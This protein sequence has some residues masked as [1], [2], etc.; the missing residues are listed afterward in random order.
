MPRAI[1][2]AADILEKRRRED[3]GADLLVQITLRNGDVGWLAVRQADATLTATHTVE[4]HDRRFM[5]VPARR[6]LKAGLADLLTEQSEILR[7]SKAVAIN[8]HWELYRDDFDRRERRS[9]LDREWRVH[10]LALV[11]AEDRSR[12]QTVRLVRLSC[13]RTSADRLDATQFVLD[14]G[15]GF[16]GWLRC[17]AFGSGQP[18]DVAVDVDRLRSALLRPGAGLSKLLVDLTTGFISEHD[19]KLAFAARRRFL[20]EHCI[21][22]RRTR[23]AVRSTG[24]GR[25]EP[26]AERHVDEILSVAAEVT[27]AA[28]SFRHVDEMLAVEAEAVE[29][30]ALL[31]H[32]DG[33]DADAGMP[34]DEAP[35]SLHHVGEKPARRGRPPKYHT[36]ED[37]AAAERQRKLA[38]AQARR[39]AGLLKETAENLRE[40][41]RRR[42][43]RLKASGEAGG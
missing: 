30:A 35:V 10:E 23:N 40:R 43:A 26:D 37:R 15:P 3:G 25:R 24:T 17:G 14:L 32:V 16:D 18:V 31:R 27:E 2:I 6:T 21:E 8:D 12:R 5:T 28:T 4:G 33:N 11:D 1:I 29:P 13:T 36:D 20:P 7:E 19:A 22:D 41:Q 38:W 34:Q 39:Q 42:R 9:R